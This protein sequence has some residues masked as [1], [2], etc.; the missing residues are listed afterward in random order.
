MKSNRRFVLTQLSA[1]PVVCGAVIVSGWITKLLFAPI[2]HEIVI[3]H[4]SRA[5]I[6][7]SA[8]VIEALILTYIGLWVWGR[9]L[10]VAGIL[11]SKEAKGYPFSRPWEN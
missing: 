11:T 5:L 6:P 7:V 2:I 9:F 1:I 8:L 4:P 10:V 3:L